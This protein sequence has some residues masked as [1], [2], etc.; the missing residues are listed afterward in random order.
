MGL[1]M[2]SHAQMS[3]PNGKT[4][5]LV[6]DNGFLYMETRLL[7][8]IGKRKAE[9]YRWEKIS[10]S[11][12]S[13]WELS[14]CFN[15]ECWNGLPDSGNFIGDYGLSDSTCF[16]AFHV[17]THEYD[18]KAVIKYRVTNRFDPSETA[19]LTFSVTYTGPSG[20]NSAAGREGQVVL[21][22]NPASSAFSV[23]L[24]N[25]MKPAVPISIF[26]LSGQYVYS[27]KEPQNI[28]ISGLP[29]GTYLVRIPVSGSYICKPLTIIR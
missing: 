22:P 28:D 6:T 13:R 4:L 17:E 14:S 18:G 5:N 3:F 21:F 19:D 12:D 26:S 15:G 7:F 9:D 11:S 8:T 16:I 25:E 10:D 24:Y 20:I 1:P 29:V 27:T 23:K 2:I